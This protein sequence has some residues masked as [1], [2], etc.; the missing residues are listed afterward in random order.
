M[1]VPLT[2]VARIADHI[3]PRVWLT[4]GPTVEPAPDSIRG[5]DSLGVLGE[6]LALLEA[7][8]L[9]PK[10]VDDYCFA[11]WKLLGKHLRFQVHPLDVTE[12]HAA[13]FL[14]SLSDH[15]AARVQYAKALRSFYTWAVRRGYLLTSPVGEIKPKKPR[16]SPQERFEMDELI[17]LLIAASWRDER[18]G[19]AILACFALGCR[20]GEFVHIRWDDIRWERGIVHLRVTKGRKPRDVDMGEWARAALTE[21]RRWSRSDRILDITPNTFTHW[22]NE[23]ATDCGFPPGRLRRAHTLRATFASVLLDSGAPPPVVQRLMGHSSLTTTSDYYA[24]SKGAGSK[25]VKVLGD[26]HR[27]GTPAYGSTREGEP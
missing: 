13:M 19:W 22:V 7:N 25:A 24:A 8:G 16:R 11:M 9:A 2:G 1:S 23:A 3:R 20:R 12:N 14:A 21:L 18:R 5:G 17:R 10:T 27:D 15:N 6:W 4:H 26:L